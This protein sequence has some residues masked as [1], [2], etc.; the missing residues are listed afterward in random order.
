ML[1]PTE[2]RPWPLPRGPWV[3]R[4]TWHDL[5]FAHWP[6]PPDAFRARIPRSL[7]LDTFDGRA[8]IGV[9]PFHM[10]GVRPRGLPPLPGLS[11]FPE[12]NVRTYVTAEE[13]PGVLF[14]SLDAGSRV[15][16]EAARLTYGL[17][18][19]RARMSVR[20]EGEAIRY[21]S[22]RV[23]RRGRPAELAARYRPTGPVF[24]AGPGTL[25][26]FLTERYCLYA[27]RPDG[28]LYRAEIHH[29][30]W[31]LQPAEAEL[32]RNS[33][34]AAD[35][36]DLPGSTPVLHFARRLAVVVWPLRRVPRGP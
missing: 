7:S 6:L 11:A 3:M 29:A 10:S 33:M 13:K 30:P 18:Y 4:Q 5:L 27:P 25:E 26:R 21:A 8:W 34:A 1:P 12:L 17:P 28:R 36:I 20:T 16:V 31:P 19:Y 23:D 14:F 15:A 22:R 32:E 2:H 24:G 35:G 9:I